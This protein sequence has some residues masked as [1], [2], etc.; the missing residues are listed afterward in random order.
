[1]GVDSMSIITRD[2]GRLKIQ[3]RLS[4]RISGRYLHNIKHQR[5]IRFFDP[6]NLGLDTRIV[7][8]CQ[9]K[10]EIWARLN[11]DLGYNT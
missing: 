7:I 9:L 4:M 2:I 6:E 3:L 11:F 10:L 5:H 8:L 1:M